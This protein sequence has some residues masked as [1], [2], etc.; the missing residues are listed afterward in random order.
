LRTTQIE[1]ERS[2]QEFHDKHQ[3]QFLKGIK[4]WPKKSVQRFADHVRRHSLD[5]AFLQTGNQPGRQF[6]SFC[7]RERFVQYFEEVVSQRGDHFTDLEVD[8]ILTDLD[9]FFTGVIQL[10]LLQKVYEEEIQFAR[11][12]SL[13]RPNEILDDIRTLVFPNRRVALQQAL[14]SADTEGDGYLQ[15]PQFIQ[16]FQQAGVPIDRD[17]LEYLFNV[18]SE[19]FTLPKTEY[20]PKQAEA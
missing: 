4:R 6:T 2:I 15:L 18:M 13:S 7:T 14:A 5:L 11:R 1:F 16:A 10:R 3:R 12:T 8:S 9:P 19:T 20:E 17:T